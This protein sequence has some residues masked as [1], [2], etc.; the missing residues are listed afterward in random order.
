MLIGCTCAGVTGAVAEPV[1]VQ[2]PFDTVLPWSLEAGQWEIAGGA[3]YRRGV[4]PLFFGDTPAA[5]RDE[6]RADLVDVTLGLGSGGEAQLTFGMQG[7]EETGGLKGTGVQDAHLSF[8]YQLP[9]GR[10]VASALRFGVKLPNAPD[11][12]RL[13]TD[14]TDVFLLGALGRAAGRWGWAGNAGLGIL[15]HPLRAGDQD[16]VLVLGAS[17]WRRLSEGPSRVTFL[18]EVHG[19]A[20]SRF[21]NDFRIARAGFRFAAGVATIDLSARAGLTSPSEDWGVEGG[22][23]ISAGG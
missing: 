14:Q 11:D 4:H 16:D 8:T 17:A 3:A 19:T 13:G 15:G 18:T 12:E 9:M 2:R 23:T 22:L 6:W 7:F 1:E 5:E 20:A 21:G 10:R